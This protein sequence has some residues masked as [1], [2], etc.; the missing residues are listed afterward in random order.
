MRRDD[1]YEMESWGETLTG[2]AKGTLIT[3]A[4]LIVLAVV[5]WFVFHAWWVDTHCTMIA[6]TQVC[7]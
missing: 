5:G 4:V 6:G 3:L 7:R 1:D 2:V